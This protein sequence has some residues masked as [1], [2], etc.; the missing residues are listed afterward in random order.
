MQ[1]NCDYNYWQELLE[2]MYLDRT[3]MKFLNCKN[4][5]TD[6]EV[7][8]WE[9][10]CVQVVQWN[11][12]RAIVAVPSISDGSLYVCTPI[13]PLF[14]A[15]PHILKSSKVS[16]CIKV[17]LGWYIHI[18]GQVYHIWWVTR[19]WNVPTLVPTGSCCQPRTVGVH[20]WDQKWRTNLT[21]VLGNY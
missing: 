1:I 15:L 7:G 19:Q 3:E 21:V 17:F 4:F 6:H 12:F 13:D 2:I 9:T 8:L 5:L 10:S 16:Q 18:G 11:Y 20:L 14:I